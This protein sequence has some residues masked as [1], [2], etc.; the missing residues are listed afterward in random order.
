MYGKIK[1][2]APHIPQ[3]PSFLDRQSFPQNR[4]SRIQKN[5]IS[6]KD[7]LRLC[8]FCPLHML[9]ITSNISP[10][11][12]EKPPWLARASVKNLSLCLFGDET[13][14]KS[15]VRA[16]SKVCYISWNF[17]T[18]RIFIGFSPY[19]HGLTALFPPVGH[20]RNRH[21]S[22]KSL[23]PSR[24]NSKGS[25]VQWPVSTEVDPRWPFPQARICVSVV[26]ICVVA[27]WCC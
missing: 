3:C 20:G 11:T 19:F 15:P 9:P 4:G 22:I 27:S 21:A 12:K 5:V 17:G 26:S 2:G 6:G 16:W 1:R 24:W 8:F 18:Q 7:V 13:S 10:M 14:S 23:L 25:A